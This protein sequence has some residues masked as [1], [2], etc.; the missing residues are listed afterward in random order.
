MK[1]RVIAAVGP[2]KLVAV[3]IMD[4]LSKTRSVNQPEIVLV[5]RSA[6]FTR[7]ISITIAAC[8]TATTGPG[9]NW[10]IL[11]GIWITFLTLN[12]R[13]FASTERS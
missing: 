2:L 10:V 12:E 8:L 1:L 7:A 9:Y 3:Y 13:Q 5:D 6:K 11:Y 4:P